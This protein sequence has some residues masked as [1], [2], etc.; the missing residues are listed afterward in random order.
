LATHK[1]LDVGS[2]SAVHKLDEINAESTT[3]QRE[4]VHRDIP[5]AGFQVADCGSGLAHQ[6]TQLAL[7]P[8]APQAL[9]AHVERDHG[10]Q[11]G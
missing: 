4:L 2:V 1:G 7:V 6:G 10:T 11:R 9:H 8:P 3:E 5:V